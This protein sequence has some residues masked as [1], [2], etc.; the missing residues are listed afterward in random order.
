MSYAGSASRTATVVA[1]LPYN[2][3]N[4]TNN[5]EL[6]GT[7]PE[8]ELASA[9]LRIARLQTALAYGALATIAFGLRAWF[10]V[11][12][13]KITPVW[14]SHLYWNS[15][16]DARNG[17]CLQFGFCA[18]PIYNTP[19]IETMIYDAAMDRRGVLP[20]FGAIMTVLP[21]ELLSPLLLYAFLDTLVCLMVVGIARRW[22]MPFWAAILA[23]AV[24]A[25]YVPAITGDGA[26][27]QQPYIRFFLVATIWA[28]TYAFT[29]KGAR[30]WIWAALGTLSSI[31]VGFTNLTDRPLMWLIQ[32]LVIGLS[33]LGWR[34]VRFGVRGARF[35]VRGLRG[36]GRG[37]SIESDN[38]QPSIPI[39]GP[40]PPEPQTPSL[41]PRPSNPQPRTLLLAQS[42]YTALTVVLL[43]AFSYH[44][45]NKT[46][47]A[48]ALTAPL[49]GLSASGGVGGQST[50]VTFEHLWQPEDWGKLG[51]NTSETILKDF[52]KSPLTFVEL[53]NFSLISNWRY[54]DYVYFQ[55]YLLDYDGQKLQHNMLLLLGLA[56]LA[57]L[58]GRPGVI[59]RVVVLTLAV[60]LAAS[61]LYSMITIEPR[62]LAVLSPF[63]AVGVGAFSWGVASLL[64]VGARRL[65][66]LR[67]APMLRW[68]LLVLLTT[69][70]IWIVPLSALVDSTPSAA[71]AVHVGMV[72]VQAVALIVAVAAACELA[73]LLS[74][75][76]RPLLPTLVVAGLM[77]S[78]VFAQLTDPDWRGWTAN[79]N[80]PVRQTITQVDGASHLHPWLLVDPVTQEGL[81]SA[82]IVVNGRV[83]KG[84]GVRT[85]PWRAGVP[86]LWFAYGDLMRMA[87]P[88][89]P[90]RTWQAIPLP[91]E[92]VNDGA[93]TVEI[94]PGVAPLALYGDYLDEP[95][96]PY[97]GPLIT[98]WYDG[99][100][101]WRWQWNASDPRIF[102]TQDFGGRN[103]ASSFLVSGTTSEADAVWAKPP[104]L[105]R[106]FLKWEAF[107]PRSNALLALE[108]ASGGK[109]PTCQAGTLLAGEDIA[110][111]FV[112]LDGTKVMYYLNERT[113]MGTSDIAKYAHPFA[114]YD[115]MDRIQ[116]PDGRVEVVGAMRRMPSGTDSMFVANTYSPTG[117]LLYSSGFWLVL[118]PSE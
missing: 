90:L 109:A 17:I 10:L 18:S 24:Q 25:L 36:E 114:P 69:G 9:R 59:R 32:L 64:R 60:G 40:S 108:P 81:E 107:G 111:P 30:L 104:G 75:T 7:A 61:L 19:T 12:V 27:N 20:L 97:V 70:L 74:P 1:M 65:W 33:F 8:A 37:A 85:Y 52:T 51:R 76:Y 13:N 66:V 6:P 42:V 118:P 38:T 73:R 58:L 116:T 102:A 110:L 100:S 44:L 5:S 94:R 31:V 79:V 80:T 26:V 103:Y 46:Q 72:L 56:G 23:G 2:A 92:L 34:G 49:T 112:C 53:W 50:V 82:T 83:V 29:A 63:L 41:T 15:M 68:G 16:Q 55:V 45:H 77:G 99:S 22:G 35:R 57:G 47:S 78:L 96:A 71:G 117:Q 95:D 106:I 11:R 28:Y 105:Y 39:N 43:V 91:R 84:A 67:E 113:L 62:R 54:P 21:A 87:N 98:P 101:F 14:D 86:P 93:A 88:A 48:D 115:L 4:D 3:A 89:P